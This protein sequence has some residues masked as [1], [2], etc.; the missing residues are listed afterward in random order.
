M[1]CASF[2]WSSLWTLWHG[3]RHLACSS[4]HSCRPNSP[5]HRCNEYCPSYKPGVHR[6]HP[7]NV[8]PSK[9]CHVMCIQN[10]TL[11]NSNEIMLQKIAIGK[12]LTRVD[13]SLHISSAHHGIVHSVS[14]NVTRHAAA[15]RDQENFGI[16]QLST[17]AMIYK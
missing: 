3:H 6:N 8:K 7:T 16:Q 10:D 1:L 2:H 15:L 12:H 14:I 17:N 13:L 9:K 4:C 5:H 11:F